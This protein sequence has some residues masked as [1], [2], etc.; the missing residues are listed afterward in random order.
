MN[1]YLVVVFI[2]VSSVVFAQSKKE[3]KKIKKEKEYQ[4][5]K[6]LIEAKK[7]EF[8]GDW[9]SPQNGQR[10]NLIGNYNYLRI[11]GDSLFTY[12]PYYGVRT[13]GG[14][15][16][17]NSGGI[18]INNIMTKYEVEYNDKKQKIQLKFSASDDYETIE[19]FMTLYG[20]GSSNI[21]VNSNSRSF[22]SYDGKTVEYVKE[23]E[24][25]KE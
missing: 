10:I 19:F 7:L 11:I 2:L 13:A 25:E 18:K 15:A 5:M 21:N 9:A 14:G 24:E 16:Y 4:E 3:N 17:S 20:G 22:I 1:K 6:L 8:V 23:E 12:M